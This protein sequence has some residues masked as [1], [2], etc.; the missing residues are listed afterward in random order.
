MIDFRIS[1]LSGLT[2][3]DQVKV[4]HVELSVLTQAWPVSVH[5]TTPK[6]W[7]SPCTFFCFTHQPVAGRA[8][9]PEWQK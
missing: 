4:I 8:V 2:L 6:V 5:R 9:L 1:F 7:V 3:Q